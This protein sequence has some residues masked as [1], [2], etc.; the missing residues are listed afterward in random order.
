[1]RFDEKKTKGFKIVGY[2]I[3][4]FIFSVILYFILSYFEKIPDDWNYLHV[5]AL[6]IGIVIISKLL[7]R[8]LS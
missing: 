5:L 1:M 2:L 7:N 6:S 3:T 8:V 4:F